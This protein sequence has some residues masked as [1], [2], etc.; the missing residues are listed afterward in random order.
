VNPDFAK[1]A[2]ALGLLGLAAD[3]PDKVRPM[4]A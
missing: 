2:D 1:V 3:T 4:L